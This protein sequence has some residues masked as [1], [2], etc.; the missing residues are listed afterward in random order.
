M[1]R[2]MELCDTFQHCI[3]ACEVRRHRD[4][5]LPRFFLEESPIFCMSSLFSCWLRFEATPAAS[6]RCWSDCIAPAVPMLEAPVVR[7]ALVLAWVVFVLVVL[8]FSL[9]ILGS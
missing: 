2:Y 6:W 8:V 3:L 4:L 7:L 5:H 9:D 1:T